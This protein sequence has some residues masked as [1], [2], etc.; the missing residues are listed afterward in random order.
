MPEKAMEIFSM[1]SN[2]D[3]ITLS[4]FFSSCSQVGTKE[5]LDSGLKVWSTTSLVN[6]RYKYITTGALKI[7]ISSGDL[8]SAENLF[9]TMKPN[10]IEYGQMMKCY[11]SH[12][13]PIKTIDLHEKMKNAGL[14]E[15][16]ITFIL[17]VDACAQIGIKS[18]C[19]SI[20]SQIPPALLPSLK[21]QNCLIHMW[22]GND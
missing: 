10:V 12:N 2:P 6:R 7:L 4:L 20:V 1:I 22:V 19:Q 14:Q 3:K 9:R 21:L 15:D 11:N 16:S 17:L 13:M 5:A 18:R 8:S